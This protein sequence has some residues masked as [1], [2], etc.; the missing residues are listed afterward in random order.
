MSRQKLSVR[1]AVGDALGLGFSRPISVILWGI[2]SMLF[3]AGILGLLCWMLS[4]VPGFPMFG[5]TGTGPDPE[6]IRAML[7]HTV[8]VQG[9][10]AVVNL[11]ALIMT[12]VLIAAVTRAVVRPRAGGLGYMRL[13]MDEFRVLV[14]QFA[15]G[16]GAYFLIVTLLLIGVGVALAAWPL[17]PTV[18]YGVIGATAFVLVMTLI[19]VCLRAS[20]ITPMTVAVNEFSFIEGWR[21]TRGRFW[22]LLG[23]V[24]LSAVASIVVS[25]L[26]LPV[27]VGF[28]WGAGVTAEMARAVAADPESIE[29][30]L[31]GFAPDRTTVAIAAAVAFLPMA[32]VWGLSTALSYGPWASAYRQLAAGDDPDGGAA[33]AL[34]PAPLADHDAVEAHD[35]HGQADHG[36][37]EG[38][39]AH[40]H[41]DHGDAAH[42]HEVHSHDAHSSEAPGHDS[43][44][45]DVHSHEAPAHDDHGHGQQDHDHGAHA[46]ESHGHDAGHES[47]VAHHDAGHEADAVHH[48]AAHDPQAVH[49]DEAHGHD[50]HGHDAHAHDPRSHEAHGH[51]PHGREAPADDLHGADHA[52]PD[53]VA[54]PAHH[55]DDPHERDGHH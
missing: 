49:G 5:A 30:V 41:A 54:D 42:G 47:H 10:S 19:W 22:R 6:D 37:A 14:I 12:V 50:A 38:H 27:L 26:I 13:G 23:I 52:A 3:A 7:M 4:T 17:E 48:D 46:A 25:L 31:D 29:T 35:V 28:A 20:L 53:H 36:H 43:H 1:R 34:A 15:L 55:G 51:E 32:W 2:V 21:L 18:R 8:Q 11:L 33:A 9:A 45:S 40:G 44:G 24:I 16:L 39:D